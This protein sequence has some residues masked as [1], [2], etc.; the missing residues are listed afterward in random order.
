GQYPRDCKFPCKDIYQPVCGTDGV[1][2][3]NNCTLSRLNLS[4]CNELTFCPLGCPRI[5]DPVCGSDGR[6]YSNSC[7]LRA[8]NCERSP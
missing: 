6:N 7:V 3:E 5:F 8:S 2:Y 1:T 4:T